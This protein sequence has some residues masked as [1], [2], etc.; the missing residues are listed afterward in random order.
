MDEKTRIASGTLLRVYADIDLL[1]L[2]LCTDRLP[3]APSAKA[4]KE[5]MDQINE[6]VIHFSIQDKTLE[7]LQM[8]FTPVLT[9]E[10]RREI[11]EWFSNQDWYGFLA[12]LQLGIE[13]IGISIV[14][15]VSRNADPMIQESLR[16]PII[17]EMRQTS[18]GILE[19]SE[20]LSSCT[21]QE[22]EQQLNRVLDI[23]EQIYLLTEAALP[24]RFEEYWGVLGLKKEDLWNAVR[25][26][27]LLI[28]ENSGFKPALPASFVA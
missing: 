1:A 17:D 19:W 13:G 7:K 6:E 27:T 18:F 2:E 9:L 20:F 8:P 14:E 24:I 12:G 3:F 10:K 11:K 26:R 5:L 21:P 25:E 22:K 28:L 23:F 4:R 16:I 15:M